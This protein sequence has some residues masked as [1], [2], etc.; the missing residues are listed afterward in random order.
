MKRNL[1]CIVGWIVGLAVFST[2]C[3]S[4]TKGGF[5]VTVSYKNADKMGVQNSGSD[6]IVTNTT[7]HIY[8]EE[9][10][11][12]GDM[13]PILLDS[14]TMKSKDGKIEL[15]GTGLEA[16]IYQLVIENG[17]R[18]LLINDV[19]H[20][21][22][23]L[24]LSKKDNTYNVSGSESSQ[25]LKDFITKY[26]ERAAIINNV[27][28]EI[29]SLKQFGGTDSLLIAAT[30]RKNQAIS[31]LNNYL[32]DFVDKADNPAESIFALGI[33]S[34]SFQAEEF[35]Q[36][37]T[38]VVNRFPDHKTLKQLKTTY[39]LQQAQLAEMRR[40]KQENSW[41]GKQVPDLALPSVDG[42][43]ISIASFRGKYLL[44]DFWASWCDPCR[45]ENPNILNAYN[46]FKDKNFTILGV[47]LD[48]NMDDWKKAIHDDRLNWTQISDLAYWESKA[49]KTFKFEGIPYNILVDPQGKVI[50]ES[51]R[52]PALI[53]KLNEVLK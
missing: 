45:K 3:E 14:S 6:T 19:Q 1:L 49:V 39:D 50:G 35:S 9:I 21:N 25:H 51:L 41:V 33:C 40:E 29:D 4:K 10:P 12:G 28:A 38:G 46:E 48:K 26:D 53:N 30:N 43:Q 2:G 22:V 24:D 31:G 16:G 20:I 18:V 52:G 5:S 34:G 32:K 11:Y 13:R 15:N 23:E 27:F 8:L 42:N 17:P 37:L 36:M 47:S 44:V 7:P